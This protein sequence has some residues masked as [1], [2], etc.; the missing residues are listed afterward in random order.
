MATEKR[1]RAKTTIKAAKGPV[2]RK[3]IAFDE[4]TWRALDVLARDQMKTWEELTDEAMRD[5][6]KKH[7]RS[8]DLRTALKLSIKR[9]GNDK[10][11]RDGRKRRN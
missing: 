2:R 8:E 4:E 1:R 10:E 3:L 6:L 5:L 11:G 7:G 9:A